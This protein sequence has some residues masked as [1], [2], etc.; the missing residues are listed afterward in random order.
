MKNRTLG[1]LGGA[2]LVGGVVLAIGSEIAAS[3]LADRNAPEGAAGIHRPGVDGSP[4]H[5]GQGQPGPFFGDPRRRGVPAPGQ[6]QPVTP[7]PSTT[8]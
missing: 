7:S 1:I 6:R 3:R 2:L 8:G 5:L 4:R